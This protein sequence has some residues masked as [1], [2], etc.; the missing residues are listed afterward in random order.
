[1]NATT[2]S[3]ANVTGTGVIN[4]SDTAGGL[5]VT[6]ATTANGD[7]TLN[8]VG[9]DLTLTAVTAGTAAVGDGNVNLSTTTSGDVL[10]DS[11]TAAGDTITI[12][13]AG[14][15]EE[16]GSDPAADLTATTLSLTAATGIARRPRWRSTPR[17][18]RWRT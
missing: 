11:V 1:M 8:A 10:M 16:S 13:S 15:I 4:L 6:S 14:A 2:L 9:G 18:C 7:I 12:T 5:A 3:V 17:R